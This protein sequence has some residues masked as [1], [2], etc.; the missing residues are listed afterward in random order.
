MKQKLIRP[1][2]LRM[3]KISGYVMTFK[4]QDGDKDKNNKLMSFR[5]DDEKLLE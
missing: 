3:P 1:L 5:T 4:V 2:I